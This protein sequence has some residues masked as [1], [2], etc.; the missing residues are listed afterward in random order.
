MTDAELFAKLLEML[1]EFGPWA[2]LVVAVLTGAIAGFRAVRSAIVRLIEWVRPRVEL[3]F[4]THIELMQELKTSSARNSD[5]LRAID[6]RLNEH[7]TKLDEIHDR[8]NTITLP[9]GGSVGMH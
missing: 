2:T 9:G 7:S 8:I 6:I 5:S 4:D 3:G 1:R